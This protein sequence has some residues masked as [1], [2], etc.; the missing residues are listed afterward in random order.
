MWAE[1]S[2][3]AAHAANLLVSVAACVADPSGLAVTGAA[4]T[5]IL[6]LKDI[7]KAST[8]E[9]KALVKAITA[10]LDAALEIPQFHMPARGPALL[11]QMLEA[12]LPAPADILGRNL[13]TD[14]VLGLMLDKLTDSEH[15]QSE[16]VAAFCNWVRPSLSRL[17]ADRTFV[18]TLAPLI[19][20]ETLSRLAELADAL[21]GLSQTYGTLAR[22]L[23][24][25]R[26]LHR[27][28]LEVLALRFGLAPA[29][30][31][32]PRQLVGLLEQKAEDLR[33]LSADSAAMRGLSDRLDNI[34]AAVEA[35]IAALRFADA[36]EKLEAARE[37]QA[38]TLRKPLEINAA[39][40]ERQAQIALLE[41]QADQAF[42]LFSAAADSFAALDPVQVARRRRTY[43]VRLSDHGTRYGGPALPL[44][45]R[46]LDRLLEDL[47]RDASPWDWAAAQNSLAIV[48][49][50]LG[51]RTEGP[52]GTALLSRAVAAYENAMQVFT[53]ADHPVDWAMTM[54][55][56]ANAL[57]AQG[58]RTAGE[59]GTALLSRAVAAYQDALQ[60]YN[61]A[62]L[63][64][65]WAATM[66]NLAA[67]L[68]AQG[69]RTAGEAGT[70]LLS[71]AVAAFEDALQ[72]FTR[73]DHPVHW[74][75]TMQNLATALRAQGE[76][77]A[78]EVG[79]A[80]LSRAVAAFE[81][82]LQ[83]RTRADH[84]VDWALTMQNLANALL[85]QGE[86]TAG[87]AGT[88]LLSR[89]VAAYED[90]LLVFNRADLP[91]NWA[92]TMQNLASAL[93]AQGE[94]TAGEAGTALLSRAVAAYE[95]AL[96]VRARADHPVQ[97]A[98][99]QENLAICH[100]A[101]AQHPACDDP[102]AHLR[103]ALEHVDLA[104]TVYDPDHTPFYHEKAARL[105]EGLL[106]ALGAKS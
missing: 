41:G 10:E 97:W 64:V 47:P 32:D 86:R 44:A 11:P 67:A 7:F 56:L 88:A 20:R 17:L 65:D 19:A 24:D 85:R 75:T 57:R 50:T 40:M 83:V 72:E 55:N 68:W 59:A 39:L 21:V 35:D 16:M 9:A 90:A 54:Q 63:P 34:L 25:L 38:E 89:A 70:A 61:R 23:D 101:W 15:R 92:T 91:V 13:D 66:Q 6:S 80:L 29:P 95:D 71:R 102:G 79:T 22:S 27:S 82:A 28:Q 4:A 49:G 43:A 12:A 30:G 81:D 36:K 100:E 73:A 18:Q 60:V 98:M 77:T 103:R 1:V 53:R 96:Q 94:R 51:E 52:P 31:A 106:A 48:C 76:R 87:E 42:T 58:E 45:I 14:A 3:R 5:G 69:E 93:R 62:D 78:G 8:P 26:H 2:S 74:A 105:R 104:L 46:L 33:V 99:T 37:V 84:P